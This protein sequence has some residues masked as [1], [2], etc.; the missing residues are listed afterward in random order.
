MDETILVNYLQG[1]C[2]D[3]E[4]ARVEAW[5]EEGPENRKT[6]EQLYYT[7]FVGERIAVMNTVDTE[8]SLDQL[9]EKR[10]KRLSGK[11]FQSVGDVM[12]LW[13]LLFLPDSFLPV[14]LP[15]D[16]FLISFRIMR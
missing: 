2:N 8:A 9:S 15:G 13:R 10:R 7:L 4:A 12:L 5:C 6:L 3:E 14:E 1:E 16:Y 11:V